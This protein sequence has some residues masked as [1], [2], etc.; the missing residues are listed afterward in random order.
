MTICVHTKL[1]GIAIKTNCGSLWKGLDDW[2]NWILINIYKILS[3]VRRNLGQSHGWVSQLL[4]GKEHCQGTMDNDSLNG[5][6]AAACVIL[7]AEARYATLISVQWRCWCREKILH[8]GSRSSSPVSASLT[9]VLQ[10]LC[11]FHFVCLFYLVGFCCWYGVWEVLP[12]PR[13][14]KSSRNL[15]FAS[16]ITLILF[17]N[18]WAIKCL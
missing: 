9:H 11:N 3:V 2:G 16:R 7:Y 4:V 18:L 14:S 15:H 10:A 12:E 8:W 5:N 13:C 6:R 17:I 1:H